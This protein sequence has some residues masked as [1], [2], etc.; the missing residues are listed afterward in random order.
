[1]FLKLSLLTAYAANTQTANDFYGRMLS[2][3]DINWDGSNETKDK[4]YDDPWPWWR[5]TTWRHDRYY[6]WRRSSGRGPS[7]GSPPI[8]SPV[9]DSFKSAD[10]KADKQAKQDY[11]EE[12]YQRVLRDEWAK[13]KRRRFPT[14]PN[15]N[16]RPADKLPGP[17]AVPGPGFD[18]AT[19]VAMGYKDWYDTFGLPIPG[20]DIFVSILKPNIYLYSDMPL[21]VTVVFTYPELLTVSIPDYDDGWKV[22]ITQEGTLRDTNGSYEFLFYESISSLSDFQTANGFRLGIENRERQFNE[23]LDLYCF[24]ETE[25]ADFIEF[26]TDVLESDRVYVMYPQLTA[27]LDNAMPLV[28]NPQPDNAFRLWFGFEA[29][30]KNP[31]APDIEKISRGGLTLVEWGGF[32]IP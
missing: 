25:K 20:W 14:F 30:D 3:D 28:A 13:R 22:G 32:I 23:I 26:W 1:M 10:S 19:L 11:E 15:R 7:W 9:S 8:G 5:N 21:E 12:I 29:A 6:P 24:N 27:R 18:D 16:V 4:K 2:G 17:P 31:D